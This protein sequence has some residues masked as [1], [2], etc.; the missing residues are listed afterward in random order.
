MNQ[1]KFL[2][3][4]KESKL[5]KAKELLNQICSIN[6]ELP[7]LY[8]KYSK[9]PKRAGGSSKF[10]LWYK[11]LYRTRHS[12]KDYCLN[13]ACQKIFM[14][15]SAVISEMTNTLKGCHKLKLNSNKAFLGCLQ[16]SCFKVYYNP[17]TCSNSEILK[18]ENNIIEFE[19]SKYRTAIVYCATPNKLIAKDIFQSE[20]I[21]QEK[22]NPD[23]H[24]SCILCHPANPHLF[25]TSGKFLNIFDFRVPS[26]VHTTLLSQQYRTK[27]DSLIPVDGNKVVVAHSKVKLTSFDTRNHTFELD[28]KTFRPKIKGIHLLP[29]SQQLLINCYNKLKILDINTLDTVDYGYDAPSANIISQVFNS[30]MFIAALNNTVKLFDVC[31][32]KPIV[33]VNIPVGSVQSLLGFKNNILISNESTAHSILLS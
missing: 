27:S 9:L 25:Y 11:E 21:Y 24:I 2:E 1:L 33:E 10:R 20:V 4:S 8:E 6:S 5:R 16:D 28:T 18:I 30:S 13:S 17:Y 3:L 12:N 22:Y 19:W 23:N 29:N 31:F 7:S 26:P 14:Y 32:R 15:D